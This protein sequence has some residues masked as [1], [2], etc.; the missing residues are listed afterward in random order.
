MNDQTDSPSAA[1]VTKLLTAIES[2][3]RVATDELLPLVYKELRKLAQ[4]KLSSL[5][6]GQTLQATALVHEA[7]LRLSGSDDSGWDSKRHFFAAAAE[8]MRRI[9]IDRY[10]KKMTKKR[11]GGFEHVEFNEMAVEGLED[12]VN[13]AELDEA[14]DELEAEHP[15][16]A[17]LVKLRFFAGLPQKEAALAMGLSERTAKRRWAFARAWLFQELRQN[18]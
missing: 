16:A 4:S 9:V 8:S 18:Q 2:G 6:P 15:E 1:Q 17:Q 10:R 14:L 12:D 5:P 3:E 7:Y 11:G 13:L